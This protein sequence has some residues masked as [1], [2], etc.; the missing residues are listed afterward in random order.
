MPTIAFRYGND[1]VQQSNSRGPSAALGNEEWRAR[2]RRFLDEDAT[3]AQ[4]VT[5]NDRQE[6][7]S[8][9]MVALVDE[10]WSVPLVQRNVHH[11]IGQWRRNRATQV[12]WS[13]PPHRSNRN[14]AP[15]VY[16]L[17]VQVPRVV[18]LRGRAEFMADDELLRVYRAMDDASRAAGRTLAPRRNDDDVLANLVGV[19]INPSQ[20]RAE[21]FAQGPQ[22][23]TWNVDW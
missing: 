1:L 8:R 2:I 10:D 6:P 23:W 4:V 20:I 19:R 7:A 9:T 15:H 22:T 3:F 5:V 17:S 13:G 21:G 12:I 14:L 11:R 16:D 18:F